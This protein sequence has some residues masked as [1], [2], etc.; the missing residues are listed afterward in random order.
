MSAPSSPPGRKF[1]H[2]W[3]V[4]SYQRLQSSNG[5]APDLV[6][7]DNPTLLSHVQDEIRLHPHRE[8]CWLTNRSA[9]G[10]EGLLL[11]STG[12]VCPTPPGNEDLQKIP[13]PV[14][15]LYCLR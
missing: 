13:Q 14:K 15:S 5:S 12:N 7:S 2:V 8:A 11:L 1:A 6:P 9:P 4:A 10:N 3:K